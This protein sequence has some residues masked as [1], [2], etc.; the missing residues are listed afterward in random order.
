[1]VVKKAARTQSRHAVTSG[2]E[3]T[4]EAAIRA[5]PH[6]SPNI[7]FSAEKRGAGGQAAPFTTVFFVVYLTNSYHPRNSPKKFTGV[8]DPDDEHKCV[9]SLTGFLFTLTL[10]I[11]DKADLR[12]RTKL[13]RI[14]LPVVPESSRDMEVD[15]T[16]RQ[17][18]ED[19]TVSP[20]YLWSV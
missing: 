2:D 17:P 12:T 10:A 5:R 11:P 19:E 7:P 9:L 15:G 13:G 8:H 20:I 1:M 14:L 6:E 18:P 16:D 3:K 4:M